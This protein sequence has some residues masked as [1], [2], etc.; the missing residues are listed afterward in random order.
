M[1]VQMEAKL[2]F[3]QEGKGNQL[4]LYWTEW[5]LHVNRQKLFCGVP[6]YLQFTELQTSLKRIK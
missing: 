1:N 6:T 3:P 5:N 4:D 2:V